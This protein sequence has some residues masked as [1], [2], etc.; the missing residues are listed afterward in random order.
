[1]ERTSFSRIST[2]LTSRTRGGLEEVDVTRREDRGMD[3]MER[4]ERDNEESAREPWDAEAN[5]SGD[6]SQ[7]QEKAMGGASSAASWSTLS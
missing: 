6:C 5:S 2:E 7:A 3:D 1:M 4:G